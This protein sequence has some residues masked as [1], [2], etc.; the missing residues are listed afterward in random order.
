MN[1]HEV[2]FANTAKR[3]QQALID[4]LNT[5][6]FYEISISEICEKANINRSTFYSHYDNTYDLLKE[7]QESLLQEFKDHFDI[8]ENFILTANKENSYLLVPEY[9][10]PFL[11]YVRNN[12]KIFKVYMN[13]LGNFNSELTYSQILNQLLVP[14][15]SRFGV[16]DNKTIDY[17]CTFFI[18]GILAIVKNWLNNNCN[19]SIEYICD[20]ID[21]CV[22]PKDKKN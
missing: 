22:N 21:L 8:D 4:L 16:S 13:N 6:D 17:M 12:R 7:T 19:D 15:C 2:K 5:K 1:K 18:N 10:V 3:I 11:E 20:I 9:I 14:I